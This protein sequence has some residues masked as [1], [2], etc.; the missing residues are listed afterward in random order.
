[1]IRKRAR[2]GMLIPFEPIEPRRDTVA[3]PRITLPTRFSER[4]TERNDG[5]ACS[6]EQVRNY[7][8]NWDRI[9]PPRVVKQL[10]RTG[11][12]MHGSYSVNM[13]V[14]PEFRR[15]ANDIDVWSKS[16]QQRAVEIENEIDKC[17]GCDIAHVKESKIGIKGPLQG[18]KFL[19]LGPP[20]FGAS[21][22]V[23]NRRRF[24]VETGPKDDVDVD[25]TYP[26]DDT[27]P[28]DIVKIG[29]VRH[30]GLSKALVRA[31]GMSR[32]MP[33]RAPKAQRD[34]ERIRGYLNKRRVR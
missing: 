22:E 1:M 7:R 33:M 14:S 3:S 25:Y 34:A 29:G 11:D 8:D 4:V 30:E 15:E 19:T 23:E 31:E 2:E 18:G 6:V 20:K 9:L 32:T 27:M 21:E 24:T 28:E 16:P 5:P 10:K 13:Q 12:I 26:Q 17:V